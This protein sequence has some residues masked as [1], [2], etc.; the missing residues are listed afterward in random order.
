MQ[1]VDFTGDKRRKVTGALA[2]EEKDDGRW[3]ET[4]DAG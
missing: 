3:P 1:P 4:T 2:G